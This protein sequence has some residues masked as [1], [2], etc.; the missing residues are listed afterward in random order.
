MTK[1]PEALRVARML[2]MRETYGADASLDLDAMDELRRL[3]EVNVELLAALELALP[4]IDCGTHSGDRA[5]DAVKAALDKATGET[6]D[7]FADAGKPMQPE[8]PE[9]M[10][11]LG[12]QYVECPACGSEGARAFPKPEEEPVAWVCYGALY[13]HDIDFD[14]DMV[15]AVPVGSLLYTSPPQRQPLTDAEIAEVAERMEATDA[16]SSFWR[17]FARAIEA[18]LKEKNT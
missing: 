6:E 7:H 15:N 14:E 17:E 4:Q 1:Q 9:Q 12:W 11:R 8:H 18:K 3:H 13:K 5:W 10:A 2:E 16:A